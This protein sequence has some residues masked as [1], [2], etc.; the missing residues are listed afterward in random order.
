[1]GIGSIDRCG[2]VGGFSIT[3]ASYNS[4]FERIGCGVSRRAAMMWTAQRLLRRA[5]LRDSLALALTTVVSAAFTRRC[6][7]SRRARR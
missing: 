2:Y 5:T 4:S 1:M 3:S 7:Q 6:A